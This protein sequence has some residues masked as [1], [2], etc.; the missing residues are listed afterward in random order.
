[1][2]T[3]ASMGTM[4][5]KACKDNSNLVKELAYVAGIANEAGTNNAAI[6]G[7][8]LP[9]LASQDKSY[10]PEK[11]IQMIQDMLPHKSTPNV[12]NEW[13]YAGYVE[14]GVFGLIYILERNKNACAVFNDLNTNDLSWYNL[15]LVWRDKK[16]A[17]DTDEFIIKMRR[18]QARFVVVVLT[19][20]TG[21]RVLHAN[22]LIYDTLN[23]VAERFDPYHDGIGSADLLANVDAE[24]EKFYRRVYPNFSRLVRPP[25]KK[26]FTGIQT[27]QEG[28]RDKRR[29]DPPG[30]CQPFTF[31]YCQ[32]RLALPDMDA[33]QVRDLIKASAEK[34]SQSVGDFIRTYA[35]SLQ[36]NTLKLFNKYIKL[37]GDDLYKARQLGIHRPTMLKIAIQVLQELNAVLYARPPDDI[38]GLAV[39]IEQMKL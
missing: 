19:L 16:L 6:C 30:Y 14:G 5:Q 3:F 34:R 18:C 22:I 37:E 11:T 26:L 17:G 8:L 25:K 24:L 28:E 10:D 1:M 32:C 27:I 4:A 7:R 23:N 21:V 39:V 2:P 9:L 20:W 36:D 38:D 31:L 33:I 12:G 35:E 13:S 29:F 15:G